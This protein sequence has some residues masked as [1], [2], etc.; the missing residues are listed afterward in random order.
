MET[1]DG[2]LPQRAEREMQTKTCNI[3]T[4][5]LNPDA[6][7]TIA[8]IMK[9]NTTGELTWSTRHALLRQIDRHGLTSDGMES[10]LILSKEDSG[11]TTLSNEDRG[12]GGKAAN[13]GLPLPVRML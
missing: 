10:T 6:G 11:L 2:L 7:S 4:I 3:C 1:T 13:H 5:L 12:D 8:V 9:N